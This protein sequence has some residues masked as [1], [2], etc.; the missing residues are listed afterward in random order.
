VDRFDVVGLDHV[1]ITTPEEL[2]QEVLRFYSECLGLERLPKPNG[3][4][5]AGGW[6]RAGEVE[7]HVSIDEHNPHKASHFGLVV[8][9]FGAVIETLR[10]AGQHIEQARPIPGR[11]RFF[12]RDPAGN[13]IEL[14]SL[15]PHATIEYEETAAEGDRADA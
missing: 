12:T 15:E 10:E 14:I 4:R 6:F 1:N 7:I 5:P 2:E 3:T 9:D 11:E 8:S 13:L